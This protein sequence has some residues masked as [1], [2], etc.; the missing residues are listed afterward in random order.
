[1]AQRKQLTWSELRVGVFVLAGLLLVVLAIFY[2]TG[3][4]SLGAK[5]RLRTFLPEVDGLAVGAPVRL[6][7][8]EVGN[9]EAITIAS[10][11]PGKPMDR[12]RSIEVVMRLT[13]KY[14]KDIRSDSK[15]GLVTEGLL[16]DRYVDI[17]RGFEGEVL[18]DGSEIPGREEK[19]IKEVVERSADVLANL[20]ALTEQIGVMVDDVKRGRGS[21]GKLLDDQTAY[22]HLNSVLTRADDMMAGIQGGQGTLGQ[23]VSSDKL[24]LR[25][26]SVAGRLDNVLEAVQQQKGSFG[27]FV[28]DPTVHEE[29]RQFLANG[30]GLLEDVRNGK[31]TIGKLATDDSLFEKYREIGENLATATAKLEQQR[32]DHGKTLQRSAILRQHD[33]ARGRYAFAG[34]RFPEESEKVPAREVLAFLGEPARAGA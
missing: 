28:Y 19:A 13:Q 24:Y 20:S 14:Q 12:N 18:Q 5:Y 16:G 6:D 27:R 3:A 34:R 32:R 8:V 4:G 26:D 30:N 10:Y 17:D 11:I 23:L 31:G 21:L 25:V 2:V 29:A 9:V 1:M 22:N 7:G 33:R 15:A